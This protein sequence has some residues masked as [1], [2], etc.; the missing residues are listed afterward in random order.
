MTSSTNILLPELICGI[1]NIYFIWNLRIFFI[2][3]P[4]TSVYTRCKRFIH[5]SSSWNSFSRIV[6]FMCVFMMVCPDPKIVYFYIFNVI[7]P[8]SLPKMHSFVINF[9]IYV[10]QLVTAVK[11]HGAFFLFLYSSFYENTFVN[12]PAWKFEPTYLHL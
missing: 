1:C 3:I 5:F 9:R 2:Y 7:D 6:N 4:D 10:W 8:S 12:T 11:W